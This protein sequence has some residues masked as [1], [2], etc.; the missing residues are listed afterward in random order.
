MQGETTKPPDLNP[1]PAG[2]CPTHLLKQTLDGQLDILVIKV[3][4]LSRKYLDQFRLCHF[5]T[6]PDQLV[7]SSKPN[8]IVV[9]SKGNGLILVP[10]H[11]L[12]EHITK[13]CCCF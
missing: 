13:I 1:L 7:R 5:L 4:V 6:N 11:V 8:E 9:A 12:L 10:I 3:A 2:Q